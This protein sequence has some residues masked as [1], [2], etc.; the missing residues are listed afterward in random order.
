MPDSAANAVTLGEVA[1]TVA[2]IER[3]LDSE[4]ADHEQRLRQLERYMWGAIGTGAAG[5]AS[6]IGALVTILVTHR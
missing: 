2:R 5:A 1:R 6:G 3:K 4:L